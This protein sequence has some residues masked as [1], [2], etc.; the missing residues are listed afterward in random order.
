M[1]IFAS[2]IILLFVDMINFIVAV[3]E[4]VE[5]LRPRYLQRFHALVKEHP[6]FLRHGSKILFQIQQ[7]VVEWEKITNSLTVSENSNWRGGV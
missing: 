2:S 6:A 5:I 3:L 7:V 1:R 4:V